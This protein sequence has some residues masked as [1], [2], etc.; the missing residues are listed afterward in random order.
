LLHLGYQIQN[1]S[2]FNQ[3]NVNNVAKLF[4][5]HFK[6]MLGMP[7]PTSAIEFESTRQ[8]MS[9]I[10]TSALTSNLFAERF[11]TPTA[12]LKTQQASVRLPMP[13]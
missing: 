11:R 1:N 8:M 9:K 13:R 6:K 4:A 2:D 3:M 12:L 10:L 5:P 7:E